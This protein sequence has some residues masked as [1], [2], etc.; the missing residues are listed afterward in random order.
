MADF[1]RASAILA[2][3]LVI[4]GAAI[5][6][7]A[8]I[9]GAYVYSAGTNSSLE[10][11]DETE[12]LGGAQDKRTFP[13]SYNDVSTQCWQKTPDSWYKTYFF[14]NYTNSSGIAINA[15]MGGCSIRYE[16][17]DS[18]G[19]GG[20]E[21]QWMAMSYNSSSELWENVSNF[22]YNGILDFE[23]NCT[24][25]SYDN[26]LLSDNVSINNTGPCI[27]GRQG[28]PTDPLPPITCQEDTLCTYDF[29]Q[30]CTDDDQ[31][32][33]ATLAYSHTVDAQ[34]SSCFSMTAGGVLEVDVTDDAYTGIITVT[35]EVSDGTPTLT[36]MNVTVNPTND[37]PLFTLWPTEAFQD[38]LFEA[39]T[40]GQITA[41]D[42]ENDLPLNITLN[43]TGC[44]KADWVKGPWRNNCTLF[45][46]NQTSDTA[47]EIFNF[48]PDNWD[49]GNYTVNMTVY[50]NE[51]Q[52]QPYNNSYSFVFDFT[53]WNANDAPVITT[54]NATNINLSQN[55]WLYMAFNGTDIENDSLIFSSVTL[56]W[57]VTN[58]SYY[59]Y[60][61]S[62][63]FPITTNGT[64]YPNESV[65]GIMDYVLTNDHVGNYTINITLT[66]NGT[67]PEN[68]TASVLLNF[69]IY[70]VND[71]PSLENITENLT[72][73]QEMPFYFNFN[74]SDPD[75]DTVYGDNLTFAFNFTQC[76]TLIGS[77]NCTDYEA[78]STFSINKTSNTS[79]TIYIFADRNDTGNYTMNLT[80]TD[81]GGLV[82]WSYIT[83]S[84]VSDWAPVVNAPSQ[85]WMNQT[86]D[87]FFDFNVTDAENDTLNVSYK[88]LFPNLSYCCTELFYINISNASYPPYINL[89]MNYTPVNNS[90][91]GNFSIEIN[92]TDMWNR[93]TKHLMNVTV[94][95]VNDGPQIN[96]FTSCSDVSELHGLSPDIPENRE[97]CLR[98]L[99][100][101]PD[102]LTPYG[103]SLSYTFTFID[104]NTSGSLPPGGNCSGSGSI[105]IYEQNEVG[106]LN[107]TA[108]DESWQGNYTYNLTITDIESQQASMIINISIYAVNDGPTLVSLVFTNESSG[109]GN[110]TYTFP[111]TERLYVREAVS[112]NLTMLA[113]DE[114]SNTPISLNVTFLSCDLYLGGTEC[115]LFTM[116]ET[117]GKANFSPNSSYVGNYTINF[118]ARDSGNI[119][120]PYNASSWQVVSLTVE[121]IEHDPSLGYLYS[122]DPNFNDTAY[123]GTLKK[124]RYQAY[125]LD[126]ENLTCYWYI[127]GTLAVQNI[128]DSLSLNP[129]TNCNAS[130]PGSFSIWHYYVGYDEGLNLYAGVNSTVTLVVE[131]PNGN[132][133]NISRDITFFHVNKLPEFYFPITSPIEWKSSSSV[134]AIDLD[135]HFR[136]NAG[137]TLTFTATFGTPYITATIDPV[138]HAVTMNS[139]GMWAGTSWVVFEANDTELSNTSNNVTLVIQ[140]QPPVTVPSDPT[141]VPSPRVASIQILV[142]EIVA[143]E[144]GK[145]S[146]AKVIFHNDG[147]Y[148]LF[149]VN[150]SAS[151]EEENITL[152]LEDTFI[153]Q[154][155]M[156]E[157]FT[158]WLNISMGEL[159]ANQTYLVTILADSSIPPIQESASITIRATPSNR[160]TLVKRDIRL[161]RDLFEENP[162]CMELF[163][164][165]LLAEKSLD[166]G[167]LD[168]ARRL[169]A[170]AIENCQDMIDYAKLRGNYTQPPRPPIEGNILLN[171]FFVM[172]FAIVVM[173]IAMIGFWLMARMRPPRSF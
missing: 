47:A 161:V 32:D 121:K 173:A 5:F 114:E 99:D 171:P 60:K 153:D 166:E 7:R 96:N 70:N 117:T 150:L 132:K 137:E 82:N 68:M 69:T 56:I 20:S 30:N 97:N 67:N 130:D 74:A 15:S 116:N 139:L 46:W 89:S 21:E 83:L 61:N 119:T 72:V 93:S 110:A 39:A 55:D 22:T 31:N 142:P 120:L 163:N 75:L 77:A 112:Y 41:T 33:I 35:L 51:S 57:N 147:E 155:D 63:L 44:L 111:I 162:E 36:T 64:Y 17:D 87:F 59:P 3:V 128:S 95:N 1:V 42:E 88:V 113:V 34:Y 141:S 50:D 134:T 58:L 12:G 169:T 151:S 19:Y 62:T 157:N 100:P 98:L 164:L 109:S 133:A 124:F 123:E 53:V 138:S 148:I 108:A 66:D 16:K 107:F 102:L 167:N 143:V 25:P 91:V 101:D 71:L 154:F 122:Y 65:Y 24:S 106:Y 54:L 168:E 79:A 78:N 6:L 4:A 9:T 10:A 13:T 48:T 23:I 103:D 2:L 28:G 152:L 165:I 172:G 8:N 140:F 94:W 170:L 92:A 144:I 129:M 80:V 26:F 115:Q 160:T 149:K 49:V 81:E 158:T 73:V 136:D 156:G 104:C 27:Y 11:W 86:E 29:S 43:I 118:T 125:D 38:V 135:N 14:A 76:D 126:Q 52:I 131:D 84:I 90:Q 40:D 105:S 159:D 145:S 18:G 146:R 45:Q 127:N 37:A 85:I